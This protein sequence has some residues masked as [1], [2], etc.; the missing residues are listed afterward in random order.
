MAWMKVSHAL[1]GTEFDGAN[2]GAYSYTGAK[3]HP[4][5]IKIPMEATNPQ[6][7]KPEIA[8]SVGHRNHASIPRQRKPPSRA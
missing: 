2:V 4:K 7:Q 3:N 1:D 6:P 5:L 8:R